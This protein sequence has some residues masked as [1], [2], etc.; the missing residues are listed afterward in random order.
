[1]ETR[2]RSGELLYVCLDRDGWENGV[3]VLYRDSYEGKRDHSRHG[4]PW[5]E[6]FI[7]CE[8]LDSR[9]KAEFGDM[10]YKW[11]S[12]NEYIKTLQNKL[13]EVRN[14]VGTSNI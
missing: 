8:Y 7:V 6:T 1:M 3:F 11:R 12:V 2:F 13:D 10:S 14:I 5:Y 4:S 9:D